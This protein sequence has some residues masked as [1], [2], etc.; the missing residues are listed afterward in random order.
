MA[1]KRRKKPIRNPYGFIDINDF[2][3][4]LISN[5]SNRNEVV[6]R[7]LNVAREFYKDYLDKKDKGGIY[8]GTEE[9]LYADAYVKRAGKMI[10]DSVSD[11]LLE[12]YYEYRD[13]VRGTIEG[14]DWVL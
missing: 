12:D 10:D 6:R 2:H 3:S 5:P 8:S 1:K 4:P 9:L 13:I 7:N 14:Q 11:N